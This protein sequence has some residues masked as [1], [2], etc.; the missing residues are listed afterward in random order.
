MA[1]FFR[2]KQKEPDFN[3]VFEVYPNGKYAV[4]YVDENAFDG[5][6]V[7]ITLKITRGEHSGKSIPV[8][9][10]DRIAQKVSKDYSGGYLDRLEYEGSQLA[11]NLDSA[12][13][14]ADQDSKGVF[15][16][17]YKD[18]LVKSVPEYDVEKLERFLKK[19]K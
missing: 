4:R 8:L 13:R 17:N 6:Y 7:L 5:E 11:A 12:K 18:G 2:K 16:V 19:I 14:Y 1:A 15:I 9:F 10:D 3:T